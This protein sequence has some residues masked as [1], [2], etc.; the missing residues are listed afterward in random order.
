MVRSAENSDMRK[1]KQRI[2]FRQSMNNN[3]SEVEKIE[4]RTDGLTDIVPVVTGMSSNMVD[5]FYKPE[6]QNLKRIF[7]SLIH[8]VH[9]SLPP[10]I[11][12]AYHLFHQIFLFQI[13]R[14]CDHLD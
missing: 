8:V 10:K 11:G 9:F 4:K 1:I 13:E 7:F 14:L 3:Q 2:I 5:T 12:E 6:Q